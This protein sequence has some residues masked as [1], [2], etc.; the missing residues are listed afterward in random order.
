MSE[1]GFHQAGMTSRQK[2]AAA[3]AKRSRSAPAGTPTVPTPRCDGAFLKG[4]VQELAKEAAC[5]ETELAALT[6]E[7]QHLRAYADH[8]YHCG[9]KAGM[10]CDCGYERK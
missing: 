6:A 1:K 8:T 7:N 4:G 5:L 10:A 9:A 3:A 2:L